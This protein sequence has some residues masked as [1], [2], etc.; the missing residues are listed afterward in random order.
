MA[1]PENKKKKKKLFDRSSE[2]EAL[3]FNNCAVKKPEFLF[4]EPWNHFITS[5]KENLDCLFLLEKWVLLDV[6]F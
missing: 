5:S 2:I 1:Q 3:T 6:K 4:M